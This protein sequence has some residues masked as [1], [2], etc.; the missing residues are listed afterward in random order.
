MSSKR[1]INASVESIMVTLLL[2]IFAAA[3]CILIFEG[4]RTYR[5][6]ITNKTQEENVRIALSYINMRIKQN[7]IED[8][9]T[10]D[11]SGFEG[12]S[13]LVLKHH[14]DEE[15]LLSYIYFADGRLWECYTDGPLDPSLSSEIISVEDI[16]FRY[17]S[18][19]NQIITTIHYLQ[20]DM[21]VQ[22]D[23]LTT[24]RTY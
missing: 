7:D 1:R 13:V 2:I 15:G 24:L 5:T 12:D 4:S 18:E 6:I 10:I 16:D 19:G 21:V 14:G 9:I 17:N 22:M 3:I 11:P 23:Q 20:G 8:H